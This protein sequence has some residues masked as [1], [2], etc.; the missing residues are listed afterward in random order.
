MDSL[1]D[2]WNNA[3]RF[4]AQAIH[5]HR[6]LVRLLWCRF[7]P[8]AGLAGMPA[9]WFHGEH[10]TRVLISVEGSSLLDEA[11]ERLRLLADGGGDGFSQWL[12]PPATYEQPTREEDLE[13]VTKHLASQ[14]NQS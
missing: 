8:T 2:G 7:H 11:A 9:G 5:V 4:G 3:G 6:A 10:G 13:F 12:L 14:S 1:E